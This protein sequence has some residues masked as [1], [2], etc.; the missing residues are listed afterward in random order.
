MFP[1][2]KPERA[3]EDALSLGSLDEAAEAYAAAC[4]RTGSK[5]KAK[6]E[7]LLIHARKHG[8]EDRY[9]AISPCVNAERST[10]ARER[11][12]TALAHDTL[13][14]A[15]LAY[16]G[17]RNSMRELAKRAG[18]DLLARYDELAEARASNDDLIEDVEFLAL[19]G[20]THAEIERRT[21][22]TWASVQKVLVRTGHRLLAER[23][24]RN[25]LRRESCAPQ[26]SVIKRNHPGIN[27]PGRFR[28]RFASNVIHA[29][30]LD[31]PVSPS[32]YKAT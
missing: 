7:R 14:E 17:T 29:E 21:G 4:G 25:T 11:L 20:A 12:A 15:V 28:V 24:A 26:S 10:E 8:L 22:H 9:W 2:T 1:G 32:A 13:E 6:R 27:K 5:L 16:G 19:Y 18:G 23:V 30:T 31:V 3:L